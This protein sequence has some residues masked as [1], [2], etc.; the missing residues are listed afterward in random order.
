M[1]KSKYLLCLSDNTCDK[2]TKIPPAYL[3]LNYWLMQ[4][5]VK[6]R[7]YLWP[8]RHIPSMDTT[9]TKLAKNREC[10]K[11]CFKY[12]VLKSSS[13]MVTLTTLSSLWS[14]WRMFYLLITIILY[15]V[16]RSICNII[17]RRTQASVGVWCDDTGEQSAQYNPCQCGGWLMNRSQ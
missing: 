3:G 14:S 5:K 16:I 6:I 10:I 17:M 13:W 4:Q 12:W 1:E 2:M 7:K 8:P 9:C 15:L 11:L